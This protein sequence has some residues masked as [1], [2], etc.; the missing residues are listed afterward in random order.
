MLIASL[1]AGCVSDFGQIGEGV[2]PPNQDPQLGCSIGCHGDDTSN[3]P[4]MALGGVSVTSAAGVGA[5]RSHIDP[6]SAWHRPVACADCHAVPAEVS[7]PGHMDG[8]NKAEMTFGPVAGVS[9]YANGSCTTGCHGSAAIGG[10]SSTPNWTRVDGSQST[11]G[12]CHGAPPP[13]PHP[14]DPNCSSCHPTMEAGMTFRDPSRH[15]DGIVDV[16]DA[17]ATGGCS[18][19]HGSPTSSAPPRDLAGN[20]AATA[21]GVGAHA[22]HLAPSTW[23]RAVTCSNCHVVPTAL[24]SPGHRDGDNLAEVKFDT[25]NPAGVYTAANATCS[26]QYC[27]GNGQGN[28]GTI[29]WTTPMTL[30]CGSCHSIN[31]TG[32]SGDHRKHLN[33]GLNCASCHRDVVD[34]GRNIINPN[35]H[36]NGVHEVKMNAG[37]FNA[38]TRQC[39]NVGCHGTERW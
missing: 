13:A 26:A 20:T 33:E 18:T 36:V 24:D 2:P 4:P 23:H 19:C 38:T 10:T 5:H 25:M 22:K 28:T 3:A 12:S 1:L 8:D 37:T 32:M 21:R 11:C 31:G 30:A 9:S 34:A 16:T 29:V 35:L 27:H 6:A 17:A 14:S 39:T 7:S 15:I